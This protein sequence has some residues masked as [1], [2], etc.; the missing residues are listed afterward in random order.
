MGKKDFERANCVRMILSS[1]EPC[2]E[3]IAELRCNVDDMTAEAIGFAMDRLFDGGALEVYTLP[4]GMKKSRPGTL[5][6]VMCRENQRQDIIA[7]LFRHT[8]TIGVRETAT[9]RYVLDRKI[10]EIDTLF[11]TV[12]RKDSCGYGVTRSKYEYDDLAR[13]AKEKNISLADV[14]KLIE[15]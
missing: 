13:I 10:T 15:E 6:R 2:C 4:I 1:D 8:T 12:R 7:L 9:K 3:K 11:G 5:I 14:I